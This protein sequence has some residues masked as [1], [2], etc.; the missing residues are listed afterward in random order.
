MSKNK[1]KGFAA[2]DLSDDCVKML[3]S[4]G[5]DFQPKTMQQNVCLADLIADAEKQ[6]TPGTHNA[7][8][9]FTNVKERLPE[10][11]DFGR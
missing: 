6:G 1:N 8:E 4:V 11:G 7:D 10:K 5:V 2:G 9:P 3:R